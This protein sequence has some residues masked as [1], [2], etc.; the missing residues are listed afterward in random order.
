[1]FISNVRPTFIFYQKGLNEKGKIESLIKLDFMHFLSDNFELQH[2][3]RIFFC[4]QMIWFCK[5]IY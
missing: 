1:M 4:F 3:H 2:V 5:R